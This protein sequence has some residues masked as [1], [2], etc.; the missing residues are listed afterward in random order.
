MSHKLRF[1]RFAFGVVG[2]WKGWL[3]SEETAEGHSI[4]GTQFQTLCLGFVAV[5]VG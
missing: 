1:A 4:R 2:G 5:S 3:Q